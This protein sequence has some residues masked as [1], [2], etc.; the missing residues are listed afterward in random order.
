MIKFTEKEL[1]F[2]A[3]VSLWYLEEYEDKLTKIAAT[4]IKKIYEG[5][6][7]ARTNIW[8]NEKEIN[9]QSLR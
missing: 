9:T 5:K 8:T 4:I 6:Q 3:A 1:K 2:I 7:N